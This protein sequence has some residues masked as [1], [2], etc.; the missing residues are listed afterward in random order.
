VI[1]LV[2]EIVPLTLEVT[3]M[4]MVVTSWWVVLKIGGDFSDIRS[5]SSSIGGFGH[6]LGQGHNRQ[7]EK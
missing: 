4:V 2:L 1:A 3:V 5:D 7:R 6:S